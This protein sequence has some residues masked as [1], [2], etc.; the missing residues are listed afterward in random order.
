MP[1]AQSAKSALIASLLHLF[2]KG[3]PEIVEWIRSG[4]GILSG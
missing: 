1:Q 2:S 3:L 4:I